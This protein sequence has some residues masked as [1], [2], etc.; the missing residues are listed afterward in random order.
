[1][2]PG[3]TAESGG[4]EAAGS[5]I[6]ATVASTIETFGPATANPSFT[7]NPVALRAIARA[8]APIMANY[9]GPG[10]TTSGG[11]GIGILAVSGG[12]PT[13]P[14][15]GSVTI[16]SSGPINTNGTGA[17]G[18][19][20]DS[21]KLRNQNN[22]APIQP[23]GPV[24]VMASG[25]ITT[26][27]DVSHGIWASSTTSSVEVTAATNV[28]TPGQF[29]VG[30]NAVSPG[31]T[32]TPGGNVTVSIPS[33]GSVMG[34][35][36]ADLT[37]VGSDPTNKFSGLPSAGVILGSAGGTATLIN[38]G[39][40]GALS[41]RVVASSPLFSSNNT[42]IINNSTITGFVQL[43]GGNNSILN[44]GTFNLRHFADT[45]GAAGGVRDTVRV[46]VA[47]LGTGPN[48]SFTNN[49]TLALAPVTGAIH[50]DNTG[51][52]LPLAP[53]SVSNAVVNNPLNAMSVNGPVQGQN[54]RR[55]DLQQFWNH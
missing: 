39:S 22:S 28:S 42:S 9:T 8:D 20:A 12:T 18:I 23:S 34:G 2:T 36:Q 19:V 54:F 38:N 32:G 52:Y 37:G 44:D 16:N 27:G 45:T 40:I 21:G 50:L 17:L 5:K 30:I 24:E 43:V 13:E 31:I 55:T 15:S 49:E 14:R 26:Q 25:A 41:D 11:G 4:H 7:Q 47:D 29:S 48:N 53:G 3:I 35:W 10:I 46:A 1:M 33:G 51:Q 6:T